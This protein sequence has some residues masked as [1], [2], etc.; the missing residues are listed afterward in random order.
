MPDRLLVQLQV[1]SDAFSSVVV[2]SR[3]VAILQPMSQG[4]NVFEIAKWDPWL[5]LTIPQSKAIEDILRRAFKERES[6]I[7]E[8]TEV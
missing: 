1:S 4:R 8:Q 7:C 6:L 5:I 3:Q 2:R